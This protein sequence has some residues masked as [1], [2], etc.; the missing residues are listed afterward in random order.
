MIQVKTERKKNNKINW[1]N[2]QIISCQDEPFDWLSEKREAT[3]WL[4]GKKE[5]TDWLQLPVHRSSGHRDR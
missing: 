1:E 2:E 5:A 3:D 4:S